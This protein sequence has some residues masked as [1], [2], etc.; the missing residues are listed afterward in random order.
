M[1]IETEECIACESCVEICP[2][3]ISSILPLNMDCGLPAALKL[4]PGQ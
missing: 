4:K 3:I 2:I 1:I